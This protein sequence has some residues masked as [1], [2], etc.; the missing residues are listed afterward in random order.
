MMKRTC[1]VLMAVTILLAVAQ[2]GSAQQASPMLVIH[3]APDA[4][5][6]PPQV[7]THA[8]VINEATAASMEGLGP[9]SFRLQEAGTDVG[10]FDVSYEPVGLGVVIVVD[11]GGIAA[12]GDPRIK[13]ATGLVRELLDRL[14]ASGTPQDDMVAVL[15]IGEGGVL[16]PTSSFSYNPVD[17]NLARNALVE[18]EA[19]AVR[20][21]TPLYEGLDGA[22]ELLTENP[23]AT[24]RDVL[25]RRRKL[26]IALSDGVDPD[27]SDVAREQDI[28]RK[29]NAADIS[30]YAVGMARQGGSLTRQAEDN[31]E[32]LAHQT[33]G[34][35]Q[36][37]RDEETHQAVLSLWDR[38]M[39]QRNQYL[40]TYDTELPKGDY[41]LNVEVE[42][43]IGSAERDVSFTSVLEAPKV[44]LT[45]PENGA[46]YT[47]PYSHTPKVEIP[48]S[49]E[50]TFPDGVERQP[51]TVRYY[52]SGVLFATSTTP[53]FDET[54][55]AT[56]YVTQTEEARESQEPV[57][58][59]FTF[60][61]EADDAYLDE[62]ARSGPVN[63]RVAW[64]PLPPRTRIE[65]TTEE[66]KRNWWLLVPL[67]A[68]A[69]GLIVLLVL[70]MRTRG[71]MAQKVV[72]T[73]TGVL[74]G[75]TRSLSAE[76]SRAPGKLVIMG[77]ANVGREFRLAAQVVK[78]GRDPQFCDFAL[79]DDYVS[80]PHFSIQREQNRY[81]ITDEG[82]RNGTKVNGRPIQAHQRVK[83]QPNAIIEAGNTRLQFKRLGGA[84]RQLQGR[85]RGQS[86]DEKSSGGDGGTPPERPPR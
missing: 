58:E 17:I 81:Y 19:Q 22:L 86:P 75:V 74:K 7:R 42:T 32:R 10:P 4:T 6:A 50:L 24:I 26:V 33:Q 21:G 69:V 11:R 67:G 36:L 54:W 9:E 59:D 15:G 45:A 47:V 66:V 27:F 12:P 68:L 13:E 62:T 35:Y 37:H 44:A 14:S 60:T 71:E 49:V 16:T 38:L 65:E 3:G 55:D 1:L 30:I 20:G 18:M 78:V 34:L 57:V 28:V 40:L 61:A 23:D 5:T 70:L 48:L 84:T 76:P 39:T 52:R 2:T 73:T 25:A 63:V 29:A 85:P 77:G 51:S 64:E 41:S 46:A 53:P 83:L 43:E 82:S 8:S 31:L 56:D 79:H 80:N 72:Q